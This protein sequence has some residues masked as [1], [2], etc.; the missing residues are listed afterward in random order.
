MR[1][2]DIWGREDHSWDGVYKWPRPLGVSL[3]GA[4]K[5]QQGHRCHWSWVGGRE[6]EEASRGIRGQCLRTTVRSLVCILKEKPMGGFAYRGDRG[7]FLFWRGHP[8]CESQLN[9]DKN[10]SKGTAWESMA[11]LQV[12]GGYSLENNG[13][14]VAQSCPT[15]CDLM[16]YSLQAPPAIHGI[17]QARGLEWVAIS[18]SRGSPQPRDWTWVSRIVGRCFTVWATREAR[19]IMR[20]CQI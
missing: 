6:W 17:F 15:L 9:V 20:N 12:R 7:T 18:F 2:C 14:E 5:E 4:L 16:D 8:D 11:I 1:A 19:K 3:P 13:S 10:E